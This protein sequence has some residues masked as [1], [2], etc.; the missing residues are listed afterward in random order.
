MPEK[1]ESVKAKVLQKMI[2]SLSK[3]ELFITQDNSV[4]YIV[5]NK[6]IHDKKQEVIN[7]ITK[8]LPAKDLLVEC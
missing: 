7:R 1:I 2:N 5:N 6:E 4:K 8:N 3:K